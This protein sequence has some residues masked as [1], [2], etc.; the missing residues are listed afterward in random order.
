[1]WIENPTTLYAMDHAFIS[2]CW[3][4]TGGD[5]GYCL[6][7][8]RNQWTI[9]ESIGG[10]NVS[11]GSET[12]VPVFES[13]HGSCYWQNTGWYL[14]RKSFSNPATFVL[15]ARE[16]HWAGY[17]PQTWLN[18][19]T[20]ETLGDSWWEGDI[21]A[22]ASSAAQFPFSPKGTASGDLTLSLCAPSETRWENSAFWGIYTN[23]DDSSSRKVV[24]SPSFQNCRIVRNSQSGASFGSA[25]RSLKPDSGGHY[26]YGDIRFDSESEKWILG[27]T[28]DAFGWWESDVEPNLNA[29]VTFA[30]QPGSESV[31]RSGVSVTAEQTDNSN[32]FQTQDTD[33]AWIFEVAAW[34]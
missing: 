12:L 15:I 16:N 31:T 33:S 11:F 9:S 28:G 27:R 3:R 23:P 18:A 6:F 26:T 2:D 25:R 17:A 32:Y 4:G 22:S 34:K 29:A 20:S 14:Y 7:K 19:V 1:M 10:L 13:V 24:G 5:D 30:W 21:P 8:R